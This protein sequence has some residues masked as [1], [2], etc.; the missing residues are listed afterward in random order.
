MAV[1]GL[2]LL[3]VC[4]NVAN[5]VLARAAGRVRA[6]DS[7]GARSRAWRLVRQLL[8]ETLLLSLA[9]AAGGLAIAYWC[10]R[11]LVSSSCRTRSPGPGLAI[12]V[13]VLCSDAGGRPTAL[14]FGL[15]PP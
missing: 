7:P 13:R 2:V 5:L 14:A 12:D 15:A 1:V 4:V 9:G 8:T 10:T 3:I 6:V 11:L